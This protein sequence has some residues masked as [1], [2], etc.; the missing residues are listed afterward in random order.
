MKKKKYDLVFSLGEACFIAI[1]LRKNNIRLFSGPFDWMYGSTFQKRCRIL[2]EKFENFLNKEDL[3]FSY[4]REF[5]KMMAY[6]NK[7]TDIT[8]NH[9]FHSSLPFDYEYPIVKN[10]YERRT[11]RLLNKIANS[12]I[13]DLYEISCTSA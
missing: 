9:D 3:I 12:K 5:N 1:A 13:S 6:Y 2:I 10:K 8:L 7:R 4:Y 11:K